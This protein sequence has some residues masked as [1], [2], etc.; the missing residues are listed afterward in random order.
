[1]PPKSQPALRPD[2]DSSKPAPRERA[3][4]RPLRA[5][6]PA[7][8]VLLT[9]ALLS[10]VLLSGCQSLWTRVDAQ[11]VAYNGDR[12]AAQLPLDWMRA[13]IGERVYVTR[14]GISV[15][16]VVIAF[17]EHAKAFAATEQPSAADMLPSELADRYIA[18]LRAG[19]ENGLP[20]L[21][22]LANSP[23]AIDDHTGFALHLRYLSDS[24]LRYE[25]L[26]AG[27]ANE[28]GF[29]TISYQAPTL[30]FFERDRAAF[31]T[32]VDSF[33]AL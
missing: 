30:H 15:Q 8:R 4:P 5:R 31:D 22:V 2:P 32:V 23:T 16:Q 26:V 18:E 25:R 21:E 1:M 19:D 17:H 9:A 14:D 3:L 33:R 12:Y 27:F 24:G 28:T 20:S 13:N 6:R 29:F 11:T 7:G 10:V